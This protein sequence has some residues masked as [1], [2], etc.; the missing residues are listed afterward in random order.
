MAD[1]RFK[2]LLPHTATLKSRGMICAIACPVLE[3]VEAEPVAVA[4]VDL[5]APVEGD[6]LEEPT[7]LPISEAEL[8]RWMTRYFAEVK[9]SWPPPN[10]GPCS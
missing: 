8:R 10:R 9:D 3:G 5:V 2:G 1:G 7:R 4:P 6:T